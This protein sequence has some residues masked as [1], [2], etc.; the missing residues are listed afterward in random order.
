VGCSNLFYSSSSINTCL[1]YADIGV[2]SPSQPK[3]F[4]T[5]SSLKFNP[6]VNTDDFSSR[7]NLLKLLL[8]MKKALLFTFNSK[9]AFDRFFFFN[10]KADPIKFR[11]RKNIY[12]G[13]NYKNLPKLKG[14]N[15]SGFLSF[16]TFFTEVS[17]LLNSNYKLDV[18]FVSCRETETS[19][20]LTFKNL[21]YLSSFFTNQH[22]NKGIVF[23]DF[24]LDFD[25]KTY[26]D[27]ALTSYA[28]FKDVLLE[29]LLNLFS[30][31]SN[32]K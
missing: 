30:D 19:L 15:F 22:F 18:G 11:K 28:F 10:I 20:V 32:K 24:I 21:H 1:H 23:F 27:K 3:V 4:K 6:A 26:D 8:I 12:F 31:F 9:T 17:S 7:K 16:L 13:V 5:S 29:E 2:I 25:L 14:R